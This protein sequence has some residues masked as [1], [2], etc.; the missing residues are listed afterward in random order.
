MNSFVCQLPIFYFV[1]EVGLDALAQ[2]RDVIAHQPQAS[3]ND[4]GVQ[5]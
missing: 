5:N 3:E 2:V 1:A 4:Y